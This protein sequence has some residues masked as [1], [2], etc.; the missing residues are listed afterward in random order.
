MFVFTFSYN[1]SPHALQATVVLSLVFLLKTERAWKVGLDRV[2][3]CDKYTA[4]PWHWR[5]RRPVQRPGYAHLICLECVSRMQA[6]ARWP[7]FFPCQE[8]RAAPRPIARG[9]AWGAPHRVPRQSLSVSKRP[10]SPPKL[11][12]RVSSGLVWGRSALLDAAEI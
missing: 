5:T 4:H 8:E 9:G 2:V 12:Q 6:P 7:I 1:C 10:W 11:A 3:V